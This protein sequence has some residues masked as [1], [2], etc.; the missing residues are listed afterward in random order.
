MNGNIMI[1]MARNV[2]IWFFFWILV[3]VAGCV[4]PVKTFDKLPPG[5]WRGVLLLNREPVIAYGDDR[6]I[7]KNFDVDSELPFNFQILYEGDVMYAVFMNAEEKIEVRDIVFG[8]DLATAKDTVIIH[9]SVFDTSIEA[10]Y[11]DGVMEGDWVVH[12]R[13]NYRI[14]FKAVHGNN[15][16]FEFVNRGEVAQLDGEWQVVM[17][18]NTESSYQA[19][20]IF[21]QE[22]DRVTG[23]FLTE[24]GD[25]R[26]LE[27]MLFGEKMY[28]SAFDGAHAFLFT[29]KRMQDGTIS[30]TFRSGSQYQV[31]W[32]ATKSSGFELSDPFNL[33]RFSPG[34]INFTFE[35][36]EGQK[37]SLDDEKFRGKIK[38]VSIMGTWCPN[39]MDEAVFLK[40]YFSMHPDT[41]VTKIAIGFERY[42]ERERSVEALRRFK[43][44]MNIDGDVLYGGYYSKEESAMALPFLEK[45]ISYPTILFIN[46]E[47]KIVKVYTGFNGPATPQYENFKKEFEQ[48]L[49]EMK[50]SI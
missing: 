4:E 3:S 47:N 1:F 13:D 26:Y 35:N 48:L 8:R 12:Y 45:I 28:L 21:Q 43:N 49:N 18:T 50:Q 24:T 39:C 9:F 11:E 33:T 40:E 41:Q 23:T 5:E 17:G 16:R 6:D 14:P 46:E 44:K 22:G 10:I 19:K 29:G 27:G 30:G 37:V 42:R 34:K 15:R 20:G 32:Q 31:D 2:R 38:I 25:Y 36:T 7:R